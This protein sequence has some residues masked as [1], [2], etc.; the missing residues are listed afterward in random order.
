MNEINGLISW[1]LNCKRELPWRDTRDPY[2]VWISEIILQQTRVD[3]GINY[4]LRFINT[5]QNVFE[6]AA[7]PES[8]ILKLWQGLGY[9]SRARNLHST[10]RYIVREL[11]GIF[12]ESYEDLL[13]L[14][15][16]GPYTAAAIASFSYRLPHAVVDGN[17]SRVLSRV[18]D[19]DDPINSTTGAKRIK[20]LAD[21]A[22]DRE[23]PD[24]HNQAIM[25]L[26][27]MVCIPRKPLCEDC[28]ISAVCLARQRGTIGTRPVKIAAKKPLARYMDYAVIETE[29]TL[30]F[31][32]RTENDIWKGLHDFA[33]VEGYRDIEASRVAEFVAESF[34]GSTIEYASGAPEI[35]ITHMLSHRR[36]EARFWRFGLSGPIE[37]NSL[38]LS[39]DKTEIEKLAVPRPIERYL[40]EA[41]WI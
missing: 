35:S 14:K 24:L 21:A 16:V 30:V 34:P 2:R 33:A 39:V 6:L 5:Y 23:H 38:Y 29:T 32:K 15:G 41:E 19:V 1:Y 20:E 25:E 36:I 4:Y 37:H 28:P 3:Q 17:V 11:N 27:A 31:R 13:K 7:A 8:E 26:G 18:Y 9:Y 10:A 22:L 40:H 12:P